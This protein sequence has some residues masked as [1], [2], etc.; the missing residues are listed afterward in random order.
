MTLSLWRTYLLWRR[1]LIDRALLQSHLDRN[2]LHARRAQI[3]RKLADLDQ[4]LE[5]P[6]GER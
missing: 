4:K 3:I 6:I 2:R 1:N 5:Q